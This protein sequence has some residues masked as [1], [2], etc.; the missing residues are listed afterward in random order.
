[1]LSGHPGVR[2]EPR[3][4]RAARTMTGT[5]ASGDAYE[6]YTIDSDLDRVAIG[7][8]LT[9]VWRDRRATARIPVLEVADG[10]SFRLLGRLTFT[11]AAEDGP[12]GPRVRTRIDHGLRHRRRLLGLVPVGR[13]RLDGR[14]D[15]A[16]FCR[17]F[18]DRVRRADPSARV[19]IVTVELEGDVPEPVR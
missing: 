7:D 8:L 12:A 10:W 13:E 3:A 4:G 2:Y 19:D 16:S 11:V 18:A 9:A 5:A 6:Q 15:Y 1:M 17:R 14:S